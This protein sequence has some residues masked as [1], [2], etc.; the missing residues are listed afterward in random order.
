MEHAN[1]ALFLS[2]SGIGLSLINGQS[3]EVAFISLTESASMWEVE[4]KKKW[5]MLPM[6][7]ASWLEDQWRN[8]KVNVKIEDVIEVSNVFIV[9]IVLL[10]ALYF[11]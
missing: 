3:E 5:K 7:H 4:A 9:T 10:N 6:E 2:L 11:N 8:Y 1:L